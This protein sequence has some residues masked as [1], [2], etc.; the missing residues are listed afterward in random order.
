MDFQYAKIHYFL[1]KVLF[2][3]KKSLCVDCVLQKFEKLAVNTAA[4][5]IFLL[6]SGR[7][8]KQAIWSEFIFPVYAKEA[9]RKVCELHEFVNLYYA[10]PNINIR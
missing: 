1:F 8:L 6:P 4:C 2:S 9:V 3:F 10:Y 5:S 7:A